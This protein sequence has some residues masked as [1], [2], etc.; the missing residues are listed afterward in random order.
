MKPAS[1]FP[2]HQGWQVM[3][4]DFG[5]SPSELLRI[6]KLPADL[7][8][9]EGAMLT[10]SEYFRFW[11][12]L[13]QLVGDRDIALC[14]ADSFCVEAFDPPIFA[15]L[16]SPNFKVALMRL[17]QFKPLIAPLKLEIET[18]QE[19]T[20]LSLQPLDKQQSLCRSLV[21][22]EAVFFTQLLRTATRKHIQPLSVTCPKGITAGQQYQAYFG[23]AVSSGDTLSLAFRT[24]DTEQA[25][26]T[27]NNGM[28][29]I[30]EPELKKRLSQIESNV[31]T[32]QR[33]KSA[34]LE[35]IPSGQVSIE[36][37]ASELA[38]SKRTLQRKLSAEQVNYQGVLN[39]TRQELAEFYLSRTVISSYEVSFL[40]GF[41]EATSFY[42]AFAAWTGRTPE[43]Y[44][45]QHSRRH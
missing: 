32:E 27:E 18:D 8:S 19:L 25:F 42:R 6:A 28:W 11:N 2:L 41:H 15:S 21:L 3:L 4:T 35:L 40:L 43:Q 37:V 13:D 16:C 9:R 24:S 23:V 39:Q 33:V 26:L 45:E 5:I 7:F 12:S 36:N 30:F 17:Q 10:S 14:F 22:M 1:K 29:N 38:M 44:R 20:R 31:A 34:L